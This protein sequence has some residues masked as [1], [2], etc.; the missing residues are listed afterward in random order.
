VRGRLQQRIDRL[1]RRHAHGAGRMIVLQVAADRSED[2]A[3]VAGTLAAA[4]LAPGERD[5]LVRVR[6][7][8]PDPSDPPCA[9]VSVAALGSASQRSPR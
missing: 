4:G 8:C 9:V 6:R 5:L 2:H 1:E 3:L 7:F